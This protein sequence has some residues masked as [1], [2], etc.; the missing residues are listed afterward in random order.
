MSDTRKIIFL[1]LFIEHVIILMHRLLINKSYLC[2][3]TR[4]KS[5]IAKYL[6]DLKLSKQNKH[7]K[8]IS[9]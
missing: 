4:S 8:I 2:L 9:F 5:L 7:F 6:V 1:F 3:L